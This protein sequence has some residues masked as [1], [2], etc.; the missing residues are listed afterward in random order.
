MNNNIYYRLINKNDYNL[1][2]STVL[3][4]LILKE[5]VNKLDLNYDGIVLSKNGKPHFKSL[6]V[7]FNY[8][9]S[10]NY[11]LVALSSEEL[12][13]DIEENRLIPD[14]VAKKYLNNIEKEKRLK[15]WVIKESYVKLLDEPKLMYENIDI[16][17]IE[18][19]KYII[20]TSKYIASIMYEGEIKKLIEI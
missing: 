6:G 5:M 1:K 19:N 15:Y 3:A 12:G 8:S 17:N 7:Y 20:E 11:I 13:V 4:R 16:D 14:N 18:K 2:N 10:K 9:H